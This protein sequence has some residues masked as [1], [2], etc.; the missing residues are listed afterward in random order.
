MV[1]TLVL[2]ALFWP[3]LGFMA[4]AL[5]KMASKPTPKKDDP[6]A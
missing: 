3:F 5:V 4:L 2:L 6:D 1:V